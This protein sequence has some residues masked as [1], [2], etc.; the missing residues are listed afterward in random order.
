MAL[1]QP[2]RAWL[3]SRHRLDATVYANRTA[4]SDR[5]NPDLRPFHRQNGEVGLG[6]L[7][8]LC[9]E[10]VHAVFRHQAQHF[11]LCLLPGWLDHGESC[12]IAFG[13]LRVD[14]TIEASLLEA[15]GPGAVE[16]AGT[17]EQPCA[18]FASY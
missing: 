1:P 17:R 2:L 9:R 6:A 15:V 11:A 14:D 16:A 7:T 13:G 5:K 10:A 18:S 4:A 8:A 3:G 12:C